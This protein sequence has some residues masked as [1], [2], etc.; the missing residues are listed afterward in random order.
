MIR[1][2]CSDDFEKEYNIIAE[3][4]DNAF[5]H[6]MVKINHKWVASI[7]KLMGSPLSILDLGT[8]T[9]TNILSLAHTY[10]NAKYYALDISSGMLAHA[11]ERIS[12]KFPD[13]EIEYINEKIENIKS[14][15]DNKQFDLI[16]SS[17]SLFYINNL[18]SVLA[19]IYDLLNPQSLFCILT[20]IKGSLR[21]LVLPVYLTNF[22]NIL[23]Y[24]FKFINIGLKSKSF[25]IKLLT[26]NKFQ[27]VEQITQTSQ[28]YYKS[29]E[30]LASWVID[31]G[32]L[33]GFKSIV[34]TNNTDYQNSLRRYL[35]LLY[36]Y[37]KPC[38]QHKYLQ[39]YTYKS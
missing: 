1:K 22:E 33:A 31:S 37:S 38:I 11:R 6:Q 16:I 3:S 27:I 2:I 4:Y 28:I 18:N 12:S 8:G 36:P 15:F 5:S 25:W 29:W 13:L 26:T 19:D 32:T 14:I 10:P 34:N 7:P 9:G 20:N 23:R 17:W 39:V 24:N 21:N 30:E 35:K